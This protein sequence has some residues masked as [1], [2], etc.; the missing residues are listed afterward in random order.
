MHRLAA[1]ESFTADLRN[2]LA[3]EGTEEARRNLDRL[4][5]YELDY[6]QAIQFDRA[7]RQVAE[8]ALNGA[9]RCR[10][11]V[12]SSTTVDHL[13]PALTVAGFRYGMLVDTYVPTFGQYRQEILNPKS[14]LSRFKPDFV[15]FSLS[16]RDLLSS[17]AI[18]ADESALDRQV[19]EYLADLASLWHVVRQNLGATILQ[20]TF[21]NVGATLFG[22]LDRRLATSPTQI[23]R[24]LNQ[25][26]L[27]TIASDEAIILDLDRAVERQGLDFWFDE[28]RW[29]Q[30]KIEISPVASMRY[31]DLTL[32]LIA[33]QRG[34]SRKCLVLDLDN[35][36]WG[37]VVGDDGIDNLV[38]GEGSSLGEAFLSFQRYAKQL[39]ERGILLAVCS[40]ND[41]E[42][43]ESVFL[44][45]PEM[46]L[47][48]ED[49]AAFVANWEDKATNLLRIAEQLN[50]GTDSLVFVDDN[51]AERELV[52]QQLPAVAVPEVPDDPTRFVECISNAGYFESISFTGDDLQRAEQYASNAQRKTLELSSQSLDDYLASLKMEMTAGPFAAI[53]IP[54]I[55][56]L[57]NKTNQ[58][59]TTT[60]RQT[61]DEVRSVASN[62]ANLTLQVRLTD[63]FGDSG[64]ISAVIMKP[65]QSSP[66][67]YEIE[68]WVMSC[69][70]F[71]RQLEHEITNSLVA[72]TKAAGARRLVAAY[73]PTKKNSL[74]RDLFADLGFKP[75]SSPPADADGE[76]NWILDLRRYKNHATH[77][78]ARNI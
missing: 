34:L 38:I 57:I 17:V 39:K 36:L 55:S 20:Q 63:R 68:T 43:A 77:I 47:R 5:Q 54:R 28:A 1:P 78:K 32:Q 76:T 22:G 59:N 21:L 26:M 60:H 62:S 29:L 64:L 75:V 8:T 58:F 61:I 23:V 69:R 4:A 27:D 7:V 19:G 12:L 67:T 35:T 24:R 74:I 3:T 44:N 9:P 48:L 52:R 33:A 30:A 18:S 70:V 13:V 14:G 37:G 42:T 41:K 72:T 16:A 73:K 53:D 31:G 50:L 71:G 2:A 46:V 65:Q 11:A 40:K 6:V 45:H 25:Q 51:P 15:L 49:I 66:D 10:L 56:Q